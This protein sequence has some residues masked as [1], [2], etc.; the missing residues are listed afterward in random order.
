[1]SSSRGRGKAKVVGGNDEE[2]EDHERLRAMME[3][4]SVL[5]TQS[6]GSA[7]FGEAVLGSDRPYKKTRSPEPITSMPK[8]S[9]Y[10]TSMNR[11]QLQQSSSFPASKIT[12]P[13]AFDQ[14][15]STQGAPLFGAAVEQPQVQGHQGMIS[16][17]NQHPHVYN[18]THQQQQLQYWNE[19]LNLSPRAGRAPTM[20][21]MTT[22][23]RFSGGQDVGAPLLG[24]PFSTTKLYRGVRQRHWGRWV[25]EIRRP[26]SRTRLWLGTFDTAE[27]AAMAYDRE[28]FRL[29]G[30][31]A[32][33]NFPEL[34]LN[35]EK[36]PVSSSQPPDSSAAAESPS[37]S[38]HDSLNPPAEKSESESP[39][40]KE[41]DPEE[42]S[43]VGS[44]GI[45]GSNEAQTGSSE[46][47]WKEMSEAWYN[48]GWGPGSPVWDD[49]DTTN[50]MF[51]D[52]N[53]R[54]SSIN[55][56]NEINYDTD[57]TNLGGS[58]SSLSSFSY[59]SYPVMPSFWKDQD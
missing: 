22:M 41:E 4:Q 2:E 9:A 50:S 51:L 36:P 8:S 35:K 34:F 52:S 17:S 32:K 10:P 12:F 37:A 31:N 46:I 47:A 21:S 15:N 24:P 28:A 14:P 39:P 11:P 45:T 30:E 44:S 20:A 48:A 26:R 38:T 49:L 58:A 6:W 16:F 57:R 25:A 29:R 27:D 54:Y 56:Q 43:G 1:M 7:G 40:Q 13:F 23:S 53:L 55:H 59:G 18:Q 5:E 42:N 33:L 19:T 3:M